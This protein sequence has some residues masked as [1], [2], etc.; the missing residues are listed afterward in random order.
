VTTPADGSTPDAGAAT[1]AGAGEATRADARAATRAGAGA[2]PG[3]PVGEAP[4]P[5]AGAVLAGAVLAALAER[6]WTAATAE[7]LTGGLVAATL[8]DVPGASRVLRGGVVAYATDL[9]GSVLG[10]DVALL[11]AHGAVHPEVARQMAAGVRRV[12][13]ADVGIATTG[14]AG[15]DPQDGFAP[16]T[17]HVAVVTPEAERVISAVLPGGRAEVRHGAVT[18]ALRLALDLVRGGSAGS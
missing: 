3:A 18:T 5:P 12:A 8:V 9:K 4:E 2:K 10:V 7:S 17:V 11:A 6:G 15:P 16:G 14:V 1:G 13:G